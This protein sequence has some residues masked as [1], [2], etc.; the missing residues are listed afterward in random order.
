MLL[1]VV[2][3]TILEDFL[4]DL[5]QQETISDPLNEEKKEPSA[6]AECVDSEEEEPVETSPAKINFHLLLNSLLMP[7]FQLKTRILER[8]NFF[9]IGEIEFYVAATT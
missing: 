7:F 6:F 8:G 9:K 2:K 3:E 4:L 1:F 5:P